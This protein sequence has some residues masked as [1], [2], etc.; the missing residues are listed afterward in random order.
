MAELPLDQL[1][2]HD[3]ALLRCFVRLWGEVPERTDRLALAAGL[4]PGCQAV[5]QR[6]EDGEELRIRPR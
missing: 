1:G 6:Q 4:A 5:C 3:R 2:V